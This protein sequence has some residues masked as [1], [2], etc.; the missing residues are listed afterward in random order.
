MMSPRSERSIQDLK[1]DFIERLFLKTSY[2]LFSCRDLLETPI[3][4]S[5]C[6]AILFSDY[7]CDWEAFGKQRIIDY[8]WDNLKADQENPFIIQ[9]QR[10]VGPYRVDIAIRVFENGRT[11]LL[12]VECDG[13]DFH[14]ATKQQVERDKKRDRFLSSKGYKVLRFSGSEIYRDVES[15]ADEVVGIVRSFVGGNIN[16]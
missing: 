5:L 8:D 9:P 14:H 13:H 1:A 4:E 3:E 16:G 10:K 2:D 7:G 11:M 12:A 6:Q 15:C